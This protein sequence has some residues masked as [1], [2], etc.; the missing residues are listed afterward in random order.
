MENDLEE[1]PGCVEAHSEMD[2]GSC[3][4]H[5][6]DSGKANWDTPGSSSVGPFYKVC[7]F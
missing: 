2:S 4:N 5:N 1:L 6:K 7:W 3:Q